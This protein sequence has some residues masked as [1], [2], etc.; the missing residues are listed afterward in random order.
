MK[1]LGV[2]V[3]AQS[4][5]LVKAQESL[6][7]ALD[8]IERQEDIIKGYENQLNSLNERISEI[9]GTVPAP[10]S[11][12]HARPVE[13]AFAK[14]ND[15]DFAERQNGGLAPN[16][17]S[18]NNRSAISEILDQATFAK[19]GFDAEFSKACTAFEAGATLPASI[20]TRIKNEFGIEIVN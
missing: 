18:I 20:L 8:T 17:I 19:G 4:I 1:A 11:L 3:K 13:R 7:S 15:N 9:G 14:G 12:R 16:Q 5:Q 2:M 6:N 10:K